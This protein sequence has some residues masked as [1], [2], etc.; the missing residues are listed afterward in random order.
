MAPFTDAEMASRLPGISAEAMAPA[1]PG[2]AE[3]MRA[4]IASRSPCTAAAK[5]SASGGGTGRAP[6]R[7]WPAAKPEGQRNGRRDGADLAEREAG[8]ADVLEIEVGGK[9]V[10][11][12]PQRLQR[13]R[14]P[15]LE[16]DE[17]ADRRRRALAHRQAHAVGLL[18]EPPSFDA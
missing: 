16:L 6:A 3:R 13:R 1:S 9:I 17:C 11:A 4:S 10:S 2:T 18:L 7:G 15:R 8:G 5:E 12:R 14:K